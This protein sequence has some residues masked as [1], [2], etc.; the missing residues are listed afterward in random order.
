MEHIRELVEEKEA[1]WEFL[2]ERV[3]A[4]DAA[5]AA[6]V[7]PDRTTEAPANNEGNVVEGDRAEGG[8]AEGG[9]NGD[10]AIVSGTEPTPE[11]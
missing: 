6:M 5:Q 7:S 11:N 10:S 9:V 3:K 4:R 8:V 1:F 2:K